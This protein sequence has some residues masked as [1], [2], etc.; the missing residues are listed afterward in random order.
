[1]ATQS[2]EKLRGGEFLLTAPE[3]DSV[4]IPED[5]TEEQT[6]IGATTRQFIE[7]DVLPHVDEIENKNFDVTVALLKKSAELGL[8]AGS[9]PEAYGGLGLDT[10]SSMLVAEEIARVSS[11]AVS[12]GAHTGIGTLPIVYFGTTAQKEKYLPKLATG[13]LLAAYALSE[14]GSGSD[15]LA[16]RTRADLSA[17]GR[18]YVLNGEK[19]WITNGGFADI[20]IVFAKVGGE[21]FTGFIVEKGFPGV[22]TGAEEH[23]MG[24]LG[25]STRPLLLS[26]ARVPVENLLGEIG[27]GHKIAF[28]ILNIGRFKLGA[29][30]LGGCK[31][32][33]IDAARYASERH[34][35]GKPILSFGAIQYKLGQM[36]LLTWVAESM[37]YRTAGLIDTALEG[38]TDAQAKLAAIEEYAIECSIIKVVASEVLDYVVDE[39]VQ[40]F[41]GNGYVRESSVER[42]YRD[43][44]INRIFE[45]TNEINRLL[46]PGMLLRRAT[47]GTLPLMAA[48]RRI[49]DEVLEGPTLGATVS[50][51]ALEAA[52]A[53]VANAKKIAL[54]V[55][56]LAAQTYQDGIQN[57]QEALCGISDIIM[58]VYMMESALLRARKLANRQGAGKAADPIAYASLYID[59]A[60]G[61]IEGFARDVL[62]GLAEGDTLRGHLAVLRR[63]ARRDPVNGVPIRRRI[64][65]KI[66]G[67]PKWESVV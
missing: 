38:V 16:A 13:E 62:A 31:Y 30:C 57:E 65:N 27:K 17:D 21:Q 19:M 56:G 51:D 1:M 55:A 5:F 23:K 36:A 40:I 32:A 67:N 49:M 63:F 48:I 24:I 60:M 18:E 2:I 11:L 61:E 66:G 46:V 33:L 20:F 42:Y 53:V 47:K 4:F 7:R 29:A 10:V 34:Q 26:N 15:A 3:L 43:A 28:N 50:D 45:G 14:S 44:R 8:L 22:S 37:V 39:A 9:V 41:G 54:V 52:G 6:M 59:Q 25:S 35:F 64:A 12:H 58:R